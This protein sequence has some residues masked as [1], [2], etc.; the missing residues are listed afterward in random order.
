MKTQKIVKLL[1]SSE[2]EYSKL[3]TKKWYAID[4]ES[5]TAICITIQ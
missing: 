3:A 4:S 2:N 1:N 5:K